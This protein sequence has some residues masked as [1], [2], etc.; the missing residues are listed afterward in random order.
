[1]MPLTLMT[2][3]VMITGS[4]RIKSKRTIQQRLYLCVRVSADTRIQFNSSLRQRISCASAD[5]SADQDRD[6]LLLQ[7]TNQRTMTGSIG[8]DHLGANNLLILHFIYL[9][10]FCVSKML[11]HLSIFISNSNFHL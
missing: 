3:S 1:M 4:I 5:S 7:K 10:L 11:K 9:K 2:L 8:I 6:T